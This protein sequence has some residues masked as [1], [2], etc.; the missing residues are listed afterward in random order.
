[1]AA[2][3]AASLAGEKQD[4]PFSP[5]IKPLTKTWPVSETLRPAVGVSRFGADFRLRYIDLQNAD[6][7]GNETVDSKRQF[8]RLRTRVSFERRLS[9]TLRLFALLN[10]ESSSYINCNAC[11]GGFDEIIFENLYL[12][13]TKPWGLPVGIRLGRQN[14]LYGDGFLIGDGTPL[15]GSRTAYVNGVLLTSAIPLWS[16]DTFMLWDPAK[17]EF[18]PRINNRYTPLIEADEFLWG[19]VLSREPATGTNLR[20]DLQPYFI[21]KKEKDG[22][23]VARIHTIGARLGVALGKG[24]VTG[25]FACQGGR[26]PEIDRP[27]STL[28][29]PQSISAFGGHARIEAHLGPPVPLDISL[30]YVYLSGD[31]LE[32]RNKFEGWNPILGRWPQWSELY[33]HTLA[34]E[35]VTQPMQQGMGYWQNLSMPFLRVAYD[36]HGPVSVEAKYMWL[37][38]VEDFPTKAALVDPR[39][40]GYKHRG[41]LY[42]VRFSWKLAGIFGGHLL[43]EKFT[44]GHYYDGSALKSKL[45]NATYMRLEITRSF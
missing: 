22:S 11:K 21:Y 16:F 10:N 38:A 44:P 12:E 36:R 41:E 13:S 5:G 25:E 32:T 24:D 42:T 8:F 15:D 39:I 26:E 40:E 20:Y 43:Y 23:R 27:E 17:D 18:L 14:I 6:S 9:P 1:M 3:A 37:N 29:G 34:V 2:L 7:L 31:E 45:E 35:A 28:A 33:D 30:G 4:A 19:M